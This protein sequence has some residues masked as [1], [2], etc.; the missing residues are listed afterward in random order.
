M[1]EKYKKRIGLLLIRNNMKPALDRIY[2]K[3][4]RLIGAW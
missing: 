2:S 1:I 3:Y 4:S